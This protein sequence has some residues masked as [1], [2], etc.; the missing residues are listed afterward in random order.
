SRIVASSH[1]EGTAYV[2]KNGY[3][4]DDFHSYLYKTTDYGATWTSISANLPVNPVN[5][6][7]E[8]PDNASLLFAGTDDG[9][10]VT[11]DGGKRWVRM[12]N[13]PNVPVRDLALQDA[14]RDLAIGSYGRGLFIANV[15]LLEETTA[16]VL[17]EDAHFFKVRPTVQR[18][19]WA[20]G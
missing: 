20:F 12:T 17:A 10:Y 5:V 3:K 7:R 2:A 11:I 9:L 8:D 13:I 18:I 4:L 6:V 14:T 15:A 19:D 1:G 16:S